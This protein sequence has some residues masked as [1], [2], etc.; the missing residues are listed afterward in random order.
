MLILGQKYTFTKL[1]LKRL[2]NQFNNI[3]TIVY[4]D[5]NSRD[6][7]N[8]IT[9]DLNNGSNTIVLNTK[10][11]VDDEIIKYL[12]NLKFSTNYSA[13][14]IIGIEHF[15][16][17]YLLKCY[18]PENNNDLHYLDDIKPFTKLQYIQKRTIDYFATISLLIF[19]YPILVY[20]RYKI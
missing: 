19:T 13:I 2:N 7:V 1:E 5:K 12:T 3:K 20:S 9:E 10:V 15:L 4:Q 14:N 11:K 16:E 18:I 17:E 8:Q 6:V